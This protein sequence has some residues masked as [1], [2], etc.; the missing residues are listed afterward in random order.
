MKIYEEE[1]EWEGEGYIN[2]SMINKK[3]QY[4]VY[5]YASRIIIY[6]IKMKKISKSI[7]SKREVTSFQFTPDC[8]YL[9][10]GDEEGFVYGFFV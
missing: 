4:L 9:F 2:S 8:K 7:D 6:D 1:G 10:A 3:E 5:N